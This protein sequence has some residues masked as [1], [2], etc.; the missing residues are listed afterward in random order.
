ME[1][2]CVEL[3]AAYG[4]IYRDG[5][6]VQRG[7]VLG[8]SPDSR[9]VVVAPV[10]GWVQVVDQSLEPPHRRPLRIAIRPGPAA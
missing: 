4:A 10:S 2:T 7:A 5:E 1:A 9:D 6:F 8:V 3:H